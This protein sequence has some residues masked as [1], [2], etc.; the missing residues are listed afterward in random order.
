MEYTELL[1]MLLEWGLGGA[2]LGMFYMLINRQQKEHR[3]DRKYDNEKWRKQA[4]RSDKVIK[5]LTS[6]IRDNNSN[7]L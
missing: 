4:E 5:E 2:A 7:K 3:E 1:E 6:V